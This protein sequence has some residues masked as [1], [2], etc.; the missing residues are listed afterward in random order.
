[1]SS[2]TASTLKLLARNSHQ[3]S[4]NWTESSRPSANTFHR[5]SS[6]L[7]KQKHHLTAW[8][9]ILRQL[10]LLLWF[11]KDNHTA[12]ISQVSGFEIVKTFWKTPF[13]TTS[14]TLQSCACPLLRLKKL[15]K[16]S[17][18]LMIKLMALLQKNMP[19]QLSLQVR[20]MMKTI[21]APSAKLLKH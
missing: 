3:S 11:R 12:K 6:L 9:T 8:L 7:G 5:T 14:R 18:L 4:S 10:C 17:K 16:N 20:Q 15:M 2:S 19:R 1:M 21:Q 13:W